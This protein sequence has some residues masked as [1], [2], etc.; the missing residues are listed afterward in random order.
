MS[1]RSGCSGGYRSLAVGTEVS[2]GGGLVVSATMYQEYTYTISLNGQLIGRVYV[3]TLHYPLGSIWAKVHECMVNNFP[4]ES[5][6]AFE[7][8]RWTSFP[9]VLPEVQGVAYML[10][11]W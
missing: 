9:V 1:V 11:L 5:S 10:E 6:V 8:F 4:T 7:S 2:A 3:V